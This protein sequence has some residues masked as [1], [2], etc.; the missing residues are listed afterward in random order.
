MRLRCAAVQLVARYQVEATKTERDVLKAQHPFLVT[1]HWAF[2]S[3]HCVHFVLEY[4]PG[5]A[6][7]LTV[8]WQPQPVVGEWEAEACWR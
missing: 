7:V 5:D 8:H 1:M 4:M 3:A 2:Q 6:L